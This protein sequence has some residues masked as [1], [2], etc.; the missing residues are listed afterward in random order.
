MSE[1]LLSKPDESSETPA[2][3]GAFEQLSML[4]DE[5]NEDNKK[6]LRLTLGRLLALLNSEGVSSSQIENKKKTFM[7]D[8]YEFAPVDGDVESAKEFKPNIDNNAEERVRTLNSILKESPALTESLPDASIVREM[9]FLLNLTRESVGYNDIATRLYSQFCMK[10]GNN[11][12]KAIVTADELRDNAAKFGWI[13]DFINGELFRAELKYIE[14]HPDLPLE[15]I[16]GSAK[17]V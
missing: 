8:L 17:K 11:S 14:D 7:A 12:E 10:S 3:E 6:E 5:M 15:Q 13:C 9:Q 4:A 16:L 1:R 2:K